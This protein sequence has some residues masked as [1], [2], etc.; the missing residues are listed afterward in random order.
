MTPTKFHGW[1]K[2]ARNVVT[3]IDSDHDSDCE[4]T[5]FSVV[6]PK[7]SELPQGSFN[8]DSDCEITVVSPKPSDFVM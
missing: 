2:R 7:L 5:G 3:V 6:S 4:I 8:S 1:I